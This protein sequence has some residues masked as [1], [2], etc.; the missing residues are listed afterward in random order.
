MQSTFIKFFMLVV[1]ARGSIWM[2]NAA[3]A[4]NTTPSVAGE[5]A[6]GISP[7]DFSVGEICTDSNL[8]GTC[9]SINVDTIPSSC[10]NDLNAAST[11]IFSTSDKSHY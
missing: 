3:P 6:A 4:T 7:L 5:T 8:S 10:F 1:T 9:V 2:E 11:H